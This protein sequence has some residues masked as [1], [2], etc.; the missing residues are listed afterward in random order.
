[1]MLHARHSSYFL[2][3]KFIQDVYCA[4]VCAAIEPTL[5]TWKYLAFAFAVFFYVHMDCMDG[6]QVLQQHVFVDF[7]LSDLVL[8]P[9]CLQWCFTLDLVM[10]VTDAAVS[11][12]FCA[13]QSSPSPDIMFALS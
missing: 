12:L 5:P 9:C 7:A 4:R 11:M 3:L 6:K 8:W 10:I 1:M 2:N 13:M